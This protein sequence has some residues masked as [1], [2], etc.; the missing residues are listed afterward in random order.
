M[1]TVD[2]KNTYMPDF[3]LSVGLEFY[4]NIVQIGILMGFLIYDGTDIG[5][6]LYLLDV[7]IQ[8]TKTS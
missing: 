8:L 7:I 6:I 2:Y 4:L 1:I 5:N 3:V